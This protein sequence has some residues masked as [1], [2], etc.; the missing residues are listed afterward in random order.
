[1]TENEETLT[2]PEF[3][4]ARTGTDV[5]DQQT[6][7]NALPSIEA[8]LEA[9]TADDIAACDDA[10][11]IAE[12]EAMCEETWPSDVELEE[13]SR[14]QAAESAPLKRAAEGPAILVAATVT[15]TAPTLSALL[16]A[17]GG[18][19]H[20]YDGK[21]AAISLSKALFYYLLASRPP[22]TGA[23]LFGYTKSVP[24]GVWA[25]ALEDIAPLLDDLSQSTSVARNFLSGP[26][27]AQLGE[28]RASRAETNL[29]KIMGNLRVL[30]GRLLASSIRT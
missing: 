21:R 8:E 5:I 27:R 2:P 23:A 24:D 18:P 13:L 20:P 14:G 22:T 15:A 26:A 9:L 6:D 19:T 1:M 4:R 3:E 12:L 30:V 17:R 11:G 29:D 25:E 28:G 16:D 10:M 7:S